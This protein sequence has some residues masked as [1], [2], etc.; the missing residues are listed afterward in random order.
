MLLLFVLRA[1]FDRPPP[2]T[3]GGPA[4]GWAAALGDPAISAALDAIHRTPEAP[5]TVETL[6]TRGG[7]S[8]AAFAKRFSATVG[9]PPLGYLT[10]WRLTTAARLLRESDSP[11]GV[12]A[13]R[14]GYGSEFAFANAFKREYGIAPGRYRRQQLSPAV[15]GRLV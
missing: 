6:A 7:L 2:S 13:E 14:V 15:D 9:R 12:V 5:W 10:W 3:Q 11:L 8:R 4:L 1:W